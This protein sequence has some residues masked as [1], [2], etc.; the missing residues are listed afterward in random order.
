[1]HFFSIKPKVRILSVCKPDSGEQ[2]ISPA[3]PAHK[4]EPW[5]G[6]GCFLPQFPQACGQAAQ[7]TFTAPRDL[8]RTEL[9]MTLTGSG[10]SPASVPQA[11]ADWGAARGPSSLPYLGREHPQEHP[12]DVLSSFH[13]PKGREPASFPLSTP[14]KYVPSSWPVNLPSVGSPAFATAPQRRTVIQNTSWAA[15]Q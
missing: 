4:G 11:Q 8:G 7:F 12:Q 1:M 9:S 6:G 10:V 13:S 15:W 14:S 3:I 5:H 2:P